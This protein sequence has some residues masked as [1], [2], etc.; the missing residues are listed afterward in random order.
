LKLNEELGRKEGMANQLG[1]IGIV[2]QN[3]GELDKALEYYGK[4][5]KLNEELG[6][7]GGIAAELGNIGNVY[8]IKGELLDYYLDAKDLAKGSSV[9][10][11]VSKRINNIRSE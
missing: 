4:A 8:K 2:Y 7:K 1:N 11:D 9:F 3:K 6:K 5:L 10:E